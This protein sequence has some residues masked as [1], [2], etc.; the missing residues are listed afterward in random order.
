[1]GITVEFEF[2][3][4]N[5]VGGHGRM[6]DIK[7]LIN[8]D[9]YQQRIQAGTAL[10]ELCHDH[11]PV[12][13]INLNQVSHKINSMWINEKGISGV[14]EILATPRGQIA[15]MLLS[16]G[17]LSVRPRIVGQVI[18]SVVRNGEIISFDFI[19][20]MNDTFNPDSYKNR[21]YKLK[22]KGHEESIF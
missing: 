16:G 12:E 18:D 5:K 13:V 6:Y 1:M 7:S 4:F 20:S 11:D 22:L 2:V 17:F 14:V 15:E 10:G 19:D 8:Y 3:P 21:R 9:E